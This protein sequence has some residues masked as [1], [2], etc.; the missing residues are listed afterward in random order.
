MLADQARGL[1][2]AEIVREMCLS[3]SQIYRML[4]RLVARGHVTRPEGGSGIVVAQA[5]PIGH[6]E[7]RARL[8]RLKAVA[9]QVLGRDPSRR[10]RPCG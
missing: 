1:T 3:P 8:A 7:F 5:S 10:S 4:E 2:P 9:A 6:W